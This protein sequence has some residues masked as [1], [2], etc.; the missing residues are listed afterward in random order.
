MDAEVVWFQQDGAPSHKAASS[1]TVLPNMCQ[2]NIIGYGGLVEFLY[3][4]ILIV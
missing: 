2:G 1:P 4:Q 3:F